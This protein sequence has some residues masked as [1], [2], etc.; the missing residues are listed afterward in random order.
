MTCMQVGK[1]KTKAED[2]L[3]FS[4]PPPWKP[5]GFCWEN[6]LARVITSLWSEKVESDE[7]NNAFPYLG[8]CTIAAQ[9]S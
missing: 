7:I 5:V 8:C 4:F 9:A 1:N 2:G 6:A 3:A